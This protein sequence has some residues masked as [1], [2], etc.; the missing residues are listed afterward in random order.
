MIDFIRYNV[1]KLA[2]GLLI[3]DSTLTVVAA[4][5]VVLW[6]GWEACFFF[7]GGVMVGVSTSIGKRGPNLRLAVVFDVAVPSLHQGVSQQ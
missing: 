7:G 6:G 2:S 3:G 1:S 5:A 4:G